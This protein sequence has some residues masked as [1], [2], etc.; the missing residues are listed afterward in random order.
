MEITLFLMYTLANS[1]FIFLRA[2]LTLFARGR[3]KIEFGEID[4]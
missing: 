3:T 2:Q 4:F 1:Y